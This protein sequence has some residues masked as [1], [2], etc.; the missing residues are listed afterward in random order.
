MEYQTRTYFSENEADDVKGFTIIDSNEESE[1]YHIA[2]KWSRED[3]EDKW[4]QYWIPEAQLLA[5]VKADKCEEAATLT[6]E[7]YE[8]VCGA[9]DHDGVVA[10]PA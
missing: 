1:E 2:E 7:Q 6:Q 5:R 8:K 9:I 3:T 4:L 10:T